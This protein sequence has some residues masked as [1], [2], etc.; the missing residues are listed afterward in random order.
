MNAMLE[1]VVLPI[2][3]FN[4][5]DQ[6]LWETDPYEY[7]RVKFDIFEDFVSPST[8]AQTL[9]HT[10]CSKRKAVL[11]PIMQVLMKILLSPECPP[12][13]KDGALHMIGTLADILVKRKT[14]KDQMENFLSNQVY[15]QFAST[16]GYL[17]ARACWMLHYFSGK[18]IHYRSRPAKEIFFISKVYFYNIDVTFGSIHII[19]KW[20][21]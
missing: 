12:A 14:Y 3:S 10:V 11:D 4:E 2:M 15:P 7:V 1:N 9:L 6:D 19:I 8:A 21:I 18:K 16:V 5:D 13:Q 20:I 17:R